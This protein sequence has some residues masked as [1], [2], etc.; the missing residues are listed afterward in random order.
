MTPAVSVV[1]PVRNGERFL[2]AAIASVLAQ[3]F[4][5]FELLVIDDGSTDTTPAILARVEDRRVRVLTSAG[6][7]LAAALNLGLAAAQG[8]YL[9]RHDA[10]DWSAPD[11]FTRQVA[12]LDAHPDIDV[13]ATAAAF[14]D[15][16]GRPVDTPWTR[17]V[18]AQWDGAV[19]PE[20]IATL[21]PLTCCLF[22]ATVMTRPDVLR[23]AGG[24]DA[25]AVPAEDYD[26][27]LRLLPERR[28]ARLPE[29]LYTVRTYPE[30]FS[31]RRRA[32]QIDRVVEAKLR[33]LRRWHP[34]LPWPARLAVP[35]VDRGAEVFRRAAPALGFS[36]TSDARGVAT[37]DVVAVTD[38]AVVPAYAA[39]LGAH[40]SFRQVGNLFVR[41]RGAAP[42]PDVAHE[43]A[44]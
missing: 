38:F 37:A 1:L 28:F 14:V 12:W 13:L 32:D 9:A 17:T 44:R 8:R 4:D 31:A 34:E 6:R 26:L 7:G 24:Y 10:D 15:A 29:R 20:A 43:A 18:H 16:Q 35:C 2:E 39:S 41:Q 36:T 23:A 27:W 42:T 25:A 5:D 21:L 22:H 11:R 33:A 19:T 3:T 30:S 40:G